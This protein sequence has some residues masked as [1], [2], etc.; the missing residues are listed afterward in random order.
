[1]S[2]SLLALR[3]QPIDG[4]PPSKSRGEPS[5]LRE[6]SAVAV[7]RRAHAAVAV[8]F[9][10]LRGLAGLPLVTSRPRFRLSVVHQVAEVVGY[11]Q[12]VVAAGRLLY[13][14]RG[15]LCSGWG[16]QSTA[17]A[18]AP[19]WLWRELSTMRA[20]SSRPNGVYLA[21]TR[22]LISP[23]SVISS[24]RPRGPSEHWADV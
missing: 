6:A 5:Q 24:V 11:D 13:W 9:G 7:A 17:A 23:Q 4:L 18:A 3:L 1:M 21:E 14:A 19:F 2:P 16:V 8:A 15:S 20:R 12:P 10:Y 22:R